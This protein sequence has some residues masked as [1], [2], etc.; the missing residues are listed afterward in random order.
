VKKQLFYFLSVGIKRWE[1]INVLF[2][3]WIFSL[4]VYGLHDFRITYNGLAKR[5][6]EAR[7]PFVSV[8]DEAK[9]YCLVLIFLFQS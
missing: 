9:A 6:A 7:K 3:R 1:K 2:E 8:W 5:S 4:N